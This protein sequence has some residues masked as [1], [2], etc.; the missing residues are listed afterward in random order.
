[1]T[2]LHLFSKRK[3]ERVLLT[4]FIYSFI[5]KSKRGNDY[6]RGYRNLANHIKNFQTETGLVLYLDNITEQIL[7]E[8]IYYLKSNGRIKG[9]KNNSGLMTNTIRTLVW[10]LKFILKKAEQKYN[11]AN[12]DFNF[13]IEK[14]ETNA[15]YLTLK[16]LDRINELKNLSKE[17]RAV[18]DRFLL[19][20][21]TALRYS[22]YARITSKNIIGG[23]IEIKT[24][25]TGIRVV[26]PMH[27][28]VRQILSRNKGEF[29]PLPS[30]QSFGKTIKRICK[31]AAINSEILQERTIGLKTVRKRVKKYTLVSSH[32]ARRT[33][34]T[35]MYLAKIP[36]FRIML[37][38]GHNTEQS[39]FKYIRIDKE[40]NAKILSEHIF[41]K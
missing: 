33:G 30:Q 32:T 36:T 8:F 41:F 17:A 6:K 2:K 24:Q 35:N 27:K 12:I 31:K 4:E 34:A 23:N 19:G 11:F 5:T 10:K 7:E 9:N 18:R 14:E 16:E 28:I 38:T 39:F 20:C 40:E 26:I 22:D 3:K 1:M 13:Q 21:F 15:V 37:L 25:K 29:P